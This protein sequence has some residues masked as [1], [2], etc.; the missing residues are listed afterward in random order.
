MDS[1]KGGCAGG[2]A[3]PSAE[4]IESLEVLKI[5]DA[6]CDGIAKVLV[7]NG[8][9]RPLV[10]APPMAMARL[11]LLVKNYFWGIC[12]LCAGSVGQDPRAVHR[13][14]SPGPGA[15]QEPRAWVQ[16]CAL[17]RAWVQIE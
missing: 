10:Q 15:L 13:A 4:F 3:F 7:Q 17:K 14:K 16:A 5:V 6:F 8:F 12:A 1:V 11:L 2:W 9:L